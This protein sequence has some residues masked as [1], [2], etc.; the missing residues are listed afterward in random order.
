MRLSIIVPALNEAEGIVATLR[1]LQAF[2]TW[3][4]EVIVVDGGSADATIK[5]AKPYADKVIEAPRGRARQMNAGARFAQGD[6]LLFLHADTVLPNCADRAIS[7]AFHKQDRVWG[8]FDVRMSGRHP[9]LR[10]VERT[11]NLRSRLTGI[12]TGDQAIFVR[13][14]VFEQTGGYANIPLMEDVALSRALRRISRP[15]C[16]KKRAITSSR[17][18]ERHG[19]VRTM[20]KMWL[21]RLRYFFGADP[22]RLARCYDS[23]S[24]P[25]SRAF[26]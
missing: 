18:W 25:R 3:G 14:R 6:V 5:I 12:A 1:A 17:R 24:I 19:I 23:E 2:R 9:L 13:R 8:R 7:N 20:G 26:S 4:H 22:A 10:L 16:I 21:L 11:M 15:A